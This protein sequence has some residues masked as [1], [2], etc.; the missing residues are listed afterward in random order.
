MR[1]LFQRYPRLLPVCLVVLLIAANA[2][3]DTAF[4]VLAPGSWWDWFMGRISI[5]GG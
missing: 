2:H 3:A 5:P 1:Q 4:D